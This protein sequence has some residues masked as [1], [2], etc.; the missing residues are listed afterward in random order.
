MP[1]ALAPTDNALNE[2][3]AAFGFFPQLRR[4]R[5]VQDPEAAKD[6]PVQ[7][8]MGRGAVNVAVAKPRWNGAEGERRIAY[9]VISAA[10]AISG[11]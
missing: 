7:F 6:M 10:A 11:R 8:G 4:N 1:N 5:T 2:P 9:L 3:S